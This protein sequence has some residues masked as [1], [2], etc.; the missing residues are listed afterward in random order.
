MAILQTGTTDVPTLVDAVS[1]IAERMIGAVGPL[2]LTEH[3]DLAH[4]EYSIL[5]VYGGEFVPV[6]KYDPVTD[7][8]VDID[9]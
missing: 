3:G 6:Y 4:A 8:L 2:V 9:S 7:M 1:L 5:Q